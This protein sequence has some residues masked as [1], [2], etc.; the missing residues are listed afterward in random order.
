MSPAADKIGAGP[1]PSDATTTGPNAIGVPNDYLAPGG[2]GRVPSRGFG[3]PST[4]QRAPVGPRYFDGDDYAP[5]TLRPEDRAVLQKAMLAAGVYDKNDEVGMGLWDEVSR[6]AYRRVLE[7]ANASGTTFS[8]ALASWARTPPPEEATIQREPL[9]VKVTNPADLRLIAEGVSRRVIG[10][11]ADPATV[12]RFVSAFQASQAQE[13]QNFYDDYE[14]G[15]TT[16]E[17]PSAEAFMAERIRKEYGA[18]AGAHDIAD[19]MGAFGELLNE[20]GG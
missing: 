7:L 14:T 3:V 20:V 11:K 12:A 8:G 18:E 15:G 6:K 13:Q 16:V 9:R 10:R 2:R 1:P 5:A 4:Y 17:T 19:Q